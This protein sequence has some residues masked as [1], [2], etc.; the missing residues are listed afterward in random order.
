M[1]ADDT[2]PQATRPTEHCTI[3]EVS[4]VSQEDC[5]VCAAGSMC[6]SGDMAGTNLVQSNFV[7]S[8]I[9]SFGTDRLNSRAGEKHC[10][11]YQFTYPQDMN[12]VS[13]VSN[14]GDSQIAV[15][16]LPG[17]YNYIGGVVDGEFDCP[18]GYQCL[19]PGK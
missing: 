18:V 14:I 13:N 1:K 8:T 7:C 11:P 10:F 2:L 15:E 9:N 5:S 17:K 6:P 3:Y 16:L 4:G 12:D 19:F